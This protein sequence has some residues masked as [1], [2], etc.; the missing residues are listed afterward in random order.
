MSN[1]DFLFYQTCKSGFLFYGGLVKLAI[2]P[3]LHSGVWGSKPQPFHCVSVV[4]VTTT[5]LWLLSVW[6]QFPSN[7]YDYMVE[8]LD[9]GLQNQAEGFESL[10]SFYIWHWRSLQSSPD[11]VSGDPWLKS[12]MLDLLQV[13]TV[14]K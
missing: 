11:L 1:F 4:L 12:R 5:G 14:G 3:D 7:T 13:A 6:V 2:T 8:W 9:I 10:Y